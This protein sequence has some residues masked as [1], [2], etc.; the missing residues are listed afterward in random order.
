ML[1]T[2]ATKG[3]ERATDILIVASCVVGC[4]GLFAVARA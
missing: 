3:R 4:I 1:K 2:I